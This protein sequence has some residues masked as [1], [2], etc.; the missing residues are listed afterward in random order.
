MKK[1]EWKRPKISIRWQMVGMML[2]YWA[3]PF[4]LIIGG[5]RSHLVHRQEQAIVEQ[6]A[7]RLELDNQICIERLDSA[8]SDSR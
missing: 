8:I 1:R 4:L 2:L 7:S 5:V 6:L 3:L